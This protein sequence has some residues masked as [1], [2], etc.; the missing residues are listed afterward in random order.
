MPWHNIHTLLRLLRMWFGCPHE[1]C[2]VRL[3]W[4]VR[5]F[6][7]LPS[8]FVCLLVFVCFFCFA[9]R[10]SGGGARPRC[11]SILPQARG[12]GLPLSGL[13]LLP[14]LI[15]LFFGS[16]VSFFLLLF[17]FLNFISFVFRFA[18][19]MYLGCKRACAVPVHVQ[20]NGMAWHCMAFHCLLPFPALRYCLS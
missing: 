7:V 6:L 17:S 13:S 3:W 2:L 9:C 14:L 19:S 11:V 16:F 4:V 1:T 20:Y 10:I 15:I 12:I 8:V 5:L 18:P